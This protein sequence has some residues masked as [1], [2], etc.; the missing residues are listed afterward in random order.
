ME[1]ELWPQDRAAL[2]AAQVSAIAAR[3]RVQL[4][5]W[6]RERG[7]AA[8]LDA[9]LS[10]FIP[11]AGYV[12]QRRQRASAPLLVGIAGAQGTGKSTA[13]ALL[14]RLLADDFGLRPAALSIDDVYLTR[15]AR[16]ALA[17]SVHPLLATRGVPGTHDLA[18]AQQT[19]DAL[20][21]AAPGERVRLP[22]FDKA[23]DDRVPEAEFAEAEGPFDVIVFEG[24]CVGAQPE[25]DAELAQPIN[26]LE[27]EQ[28][29]DGRFRR[30]VNA[31][32]AGGY[33]AL[34]RRIDLLV[35][36]AAPDL[37]SS[38]AWRIRQ[39]HELAARLGPGARVMDD[40]AIARFVQHYERI[41]RH[42]LREAPARAD[43][44][45]YLDR[46]HRFCAASVK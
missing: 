35:F 45:L 26:A 33:Q 43:V 23:R 39:E 40:A 3:A 27:R 41:S 25:A 24:W 17:R 18:L 38:L 37:Q 2:G 44:V 28:D 30:Y 19:L 34:W 46:E 14:T 21:A 10:V 9:L 22:R 5:A 15:A 7:L 4:A 6:A 42:M 12:A 29:P 36:L 31:Q 32:L 16:E 8:E 1:R 13:A 11:L 20:G